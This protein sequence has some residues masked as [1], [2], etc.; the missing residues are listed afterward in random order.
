MFTS[1]ERELEVG[2]GREMEELGFSSNKNFRN[3]CVILPEIYVSFPQLPVKTL[4]MYQIFMTMYIYIYINLYIYIN[5]YSNTIT[6]IEYKYV[7]L[8]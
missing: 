5:V 2:V 7:S 4:Y 8:L 3:L 1:F 6:I